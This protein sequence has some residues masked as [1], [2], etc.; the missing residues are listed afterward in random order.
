MINLDKNGKPLRPGDRLARPA[1]DR[2]PAA[3]RRIMGR[4]IRRRRRERDGRLP[5]GRSRMELDPHASARGGE[6]HIQIPFPLRVSGAP[7]DRAVR[8][9][10]RQPGGLHAVRLREAALGGGAGIG[11]GRRVP[12][13][14]ALLTELIPP[15]GRA[16]RDHAGGGRGDRHP[17]RVAADRRR[18]RQGLRGAR[19][20][21]HRAAVRLPEF[22]HVRHDQHHP[23]ALHRNHP[24]HPALSL[25]GAGRVRPGSADQPRLLDG[26][27]V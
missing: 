17:R 20:R 25:G 26:E 24:A 4:G 10:G 23:Q 8:R 15:A 2:G 16:G 14:P 1:P 5:A 27:L 13:D 7:P 12:I 21:L 22:R 11:N 19:R 9:F 18:G 6:E 3:G